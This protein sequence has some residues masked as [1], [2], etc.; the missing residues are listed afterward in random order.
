MNVAQLS[1]AELFDLKSAVNSELNRR[2]SLAA[3]DFLWSLCAYYGV[4]YTAFRGATRRQYSDIKRIA[5]Y[6]FV[7]M[8][9]LIKRRSG[10][11]YRHQSGNGWAARSAGFV[12]QKER[13]R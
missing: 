9:G 3:D 13:A 11:T 12:F 2:I 6:Y 4:D 8:K 5:S 7:A 1:L 10:R